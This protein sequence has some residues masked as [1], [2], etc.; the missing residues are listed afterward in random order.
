VWFLPYSLEADRRIGRPPAAPAAYVEAQ[1]AN[2]PTLQVPAA[3]SHAIYQ[4]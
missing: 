2:P 1:R 4:R 3:A